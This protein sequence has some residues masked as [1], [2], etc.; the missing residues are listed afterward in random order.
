MLFNLCQERGMRELFRAVEIEVPK[1][2]DLGAVLIAFIQRRFP[3]MRV[4]LKNVDR[5]ALKVCRVTYTKDGL[6]DL[7]AVE[8]EHFS[9]Q[10]QSVVEE[11][12][13][14]YLSHQQT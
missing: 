6:R 11:F 10:V 1:T 7:P 3:W 14:I 5:S 12:S 13:R 9:A 4:D 8:Q 2:F